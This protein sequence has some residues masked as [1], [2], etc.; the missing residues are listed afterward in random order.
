[1]HCLT[2][3]F[4]TYYDDECSLRKLTP[5]QYLTHPRFHVHGA[6]F[7][8]DSLSPPPGTDPLAPK[9]RWLWADKLPA[10]FAAIDWSKTILISHNAGFDGAVLAWHYGCTPHLYVDTMGMARA[11]V[12]A[13]TGSASLATVA[14]HLGLTPKGTT[15][16]RTKGLTTEAIRADADLAK[17]FESYGVDDSDI[18]Y[19]IYHLLK[20]QMTPTEFK[21]MDMVVRMAVKPQLTLNLDV[22]RAHYHN[23]VTDKEKLLAFLA[24]PAAREAIGV[25]VE[26]GTLLSNEKFANALARVG[27]EVPMKWSPKQSAYVPALAKTDE[28]FRALLEHSNGYVQALAAARLGVKSTI[29]ETRTARFISIGEAKWPAL[30]YKDSP[31][32]PGRP[33][34][35]F[36]L[37]YSGAHT[38]RLSGD[39]SLNMQNLGRTS[40]LRASLEAP[41]GHV[42]IAPD[43]SQIEAR[44][45]AWIAGAKKL[46]DAFR[47]KR[48]PYCDLA[49]VIYNR[50]ITK[51]DAFE[52][53]VGKTGVL[54]LG[55]GMGAQRFMVTCANQGKVISPE[56]AH[57]AVSAY[58]SEYYQVKEFWSLCDQILGAMVRRE[59]RPFRD[60]F[61][62]NV[63][64]SITLP[65]GMRL[66]YN[67]LQ[68]T[69]NEAGRESFV[70]RYGREW[71]GIFGGML[72]EN[73][74]QAL[75]RI[76]VMDAAVRI[77]YER[78]VPYYPAGQA[79]DQLI[80][81]V[82]ESEAEAILAIVIEEMSRPPWWAPDLPLAAEGKPG[83]NFLEA[84]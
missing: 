65:N 38:H 27:V 75:A 77:R 22:L 72:T 35:P 83:R 32:P 82:P 56:L 80:Y 52:R 70:Y 76:I 17:E 67:D 50:T 2:L 11:T 59:A 63:D 54:G 31:V 43:A 79:H 8:I 78:K 71:K 40:P 5:A 68:V 37:R 18:C 6:S 69:R 47:L 53:F 81:V 16:A 19:G 61:H 29:E 84:K 39:W 23:V 34:M 20:N 41:P 3:D 14:A 51:A 42:V 24:T 33:V 55:Y 49:S 45:V 74:V 57:R 9:A 7:R 30:A 64:Q 1:M 12:Y 48:D 10:F 13:Y 26:K 73:L 21:I 15:L 66:F 44:G 25:D 28:G 62:V 4:E 58:R 46:L 36:P 60:I